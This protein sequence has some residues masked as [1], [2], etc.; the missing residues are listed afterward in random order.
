VTIAVILRSEATKD[1]TRHRGGAGSFGLRPQ[2]DSKNDL[3]PD[4]KIE[5]D[6]ERDLHPVPDPHK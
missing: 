1:P 3:E 4:R 2:D 5:R 6:L